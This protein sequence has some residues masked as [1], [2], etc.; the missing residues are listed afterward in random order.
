MTR[1]KHSKCQ[2]GRLKFS[3]NGINFFIVSNFQILTPDS[4]TRANFTPCPPSGENFLS[5][6]PAKIFRQ[7]KQLFYLF[8]FSHSDFRFGYLTEFYPRTPRKFYKCQTGLLKFSDNGISF[9]I[10]SNF[11]I[12]NSDSDNRANFTP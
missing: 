9:F 10:F 11:H 2:T 1:R 7:R 12:L 8:E 6:R 4:D 3:D 5:D